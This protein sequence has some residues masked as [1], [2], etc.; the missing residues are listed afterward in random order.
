[1]PFVRQKTPTTPTSRKI[2]RPYSKTTT[3]ILKADKDSKKEVVGVYL[4]LRPNFNN[5]SQSVLQLDDQQVKTISP[6]G[7]TTYNYK[8]THVFDAK[9][10]QKEIFDRVAQSVVEDVIS[11]G[12][13]GLIFTYGVTSSGKTH[14][15]E[16]AP[17][18]PGLIFRTVDFIFNSIEHQQTARGQIESTGQNTFRLC[19]FKREIHNSNH[20]KVETSRTPSI[21]KWINRKKETGKVSAD[22][23][24]YYAVF[25]SLIELYNKQVVDL[26]EDL[27]ND[28]GRKRK[29]IREDMRGVSY[30]ANAVEKEVK[31]ADEAIELFNKGLA[32]RTVAKTAL[33]SESSRSHCVFNLKLVQVKKTFHDDF[34]DTTLFAS[35]LCLVDLA[36]SERAKRSHATGGTLHEAG[37]INNSLGALRKCIKA[38]RNREQ[39]GN[40]QYREYSLTRLFKSYFEGHGTVR[41]VLCIN[42]KAEEFQENNFAM[43]FGVLTQDVTIDYASPPKLLKRTS[44]CIQD[45]TAMYEFL[46]DKS[47]APKMDLASTKKDEEFLKEWISQLKHRRAKR[48]KVLNSIIGAQTEVRQNILTTMNENSSLKRR[49]EDTDVVEQKSNKIRSLEHD[50]KALKLKIFDMHQKRLRKTMQ[51]KYRDEREQMDEDEVNDQEE[52]DQDEMYNQDESNNDD[53]AED[54][55]DN[56]DVDEERNGRNSRNDVNRNIHCAESPTPQSSYVSNS[57]ARLFGS[58]TNGV[59]VA[60][61]RHNRSLSTG[62]LQWIYH[63]PPGTVDT[64]T[65]F[66][67]KIKNRKSVR[68]LRSSDILRKDA[69]GYSVVHQ[70][71][72][73]NGGIETSVYKGQII[74]TVCGGAQVILND[75]EKLKQVSPTINR[76]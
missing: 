34:D 26:F 4:R 46:N 23:S 7:H 43:D 41:M 57:P 40:P 35:Q 52:M 20:S 75:V 13:N 68:V 69:G 16:G 33:N 72:D 71:A 70:D 17:S 10:T 27:D 51:Y 2:A 58:P 24:T 63:N 73:Q 64:G 56:I 50:I 60:N 5:E 15:M 37:N 74:S 12:K 48:K 55:D 31:S 61:P 3:T 49:V 21:V 53:D 25:I 62:S 67:P 6:D 38:L 1:M 9:A 19:D 14:T 18:N 65:V 32:R 29:E 28:R 54:D 39:S 45:Y 44:N 47:Q 59:P 66:K 8:F 76:S 36:G 30:V 42:P 11:V 22:P